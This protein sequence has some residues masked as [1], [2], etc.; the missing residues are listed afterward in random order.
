MNSTFVS[1]ATLIKSNLGEVSDKYFNEYF[2]GCLERLFR[3]Q[4][5]PIL[6]CPGNDFTNILFDLN[7]WLASFFEIS[8]KYNWQDGGIGRILQQNSNKIL[9]NLKITSEQSK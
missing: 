6:T 2:I 8:S 3:M 5:N 4:K 9:I 7:I 1:T